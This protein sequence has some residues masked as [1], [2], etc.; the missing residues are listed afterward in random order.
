MA[1]IPCNV[2]NLV[3]DL[4]GPRACTPAGIIEMLK[5]Y[6]IP[7]AGQARGGGGAQRYRGQAGRAAAAARARHRHHLPFEDAGPG[8]RCAARRDILVAAMGRPAM[9]T[10]GVHQAGR[11]GDRCGHEPRGHRATR[12]ARIF[13][14]APEKLA[15]FDK[16]GSVLV[17]DV[18]PLDVAE[19]ASA[20]T[21]GAGRRR[22]A[23]DRHADGQHGG[24]GGAAGRSML[25]VGLT[26]GLACGKSFV[27]EALAGSGMP[28]DPG[29]RAGA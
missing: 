11:H 7:I 20:Y 4:P 21:P 10:G 18:H 12:S 25:K 23:D 29:R 15:A 16:K 5:R 17:G 22:A 9:I 24:L 28:A 27:G 6:G 8:R 14:N 3:A 26:G 2:G 1:S 19:K 13:R